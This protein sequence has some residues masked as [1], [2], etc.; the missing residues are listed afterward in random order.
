MLNSKLF[1]L[2]LISIISLRGFS[3]ENY[4]IEKSFYNDKRGNENFKK[5]KNK[6]FSRDNPSS[7]I[8][9]NWIKLKITNL[10]K[11][12]EYCISSKIPIQNL[13]FYSEGKKYNLGYGSP[14]NKRYFRIGL[15]VALLDIPFKKNIEYFV[16]L[17][18]E[19]SNIEFEIIEK[20]TL[21]NKNA[22]SDQ[23][24]VFFSGIF[25]VMFL[26]N[27]FLYFSIKEKSQLFYTISIFFSLLLWLNNASF[28]SRFVYPNYSVSLDFKIGLIISAIY[29]V[30]LILFTQSFLRLKFNYPNWNKYFNFLI[31]ILMLIPLIQFLFK[32]DPFLLNGP[33]FLS[34]L[35]LFLSILLLSFIILIRKQRE[36]LYFFIGNIVFF[37][38][39]I[40]FFLSVMELIPKIDFHIFSMETGT[41]FQMLF[42]SFAIADKINILKKDNEIANRKVIQQLQENNEIKSEINT[43]LEIE[44]KER[45]FEIE[46]QKNKLQEKN[47]EI[48]DSITY[49][50]RIQSAILPQPKLVKE[51][52]EDS[53]VLYKPKDIV[54]GDFY[55]LEVVGDTVLFA[56]ADCTGHGVPGAMVSV[57]CNNGLNRAVREHKLTEPNQIL[58]KTRELV[59]EEFEKSDEEVKDGMDI[60]LCA[61][62]T[63]TNTLKWAGAN[64]PLWILRKNEQGLV[65]VLETKPDKQPIGKHFD[66]KPF[67][68]TEFQ[69]EKDDIIYIFTDGY[70]DQFGGPKEKKYRVAQMRELFL[71][72]TSKTMEEQRKIINESFENWKGVLEQV[73]DVCIIGVR[74]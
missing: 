1:V 18:S 53:F 30:F 24:Q 65:E 10:S 27:L 46:A 69:L 12:T 23:V 33:S 29:G 45:T 31:F 71:S 52:L 13:Y 35:I 8:G 59:V 48:T 60:S 7:T 55:W 11:K 41:V 14:I 42:F 72:L 19:I 68:L 58:N 70:Q 15:N 28:F 2:I 21:I 20:Q 74:I 43:R 6:I 22:S 47:K 51:F 62:N 61:L 4:I 50:K 57:V 37:L 40:Y 66:A 54:A 56:A 5:I 39:A 63:K 67:S 36:I 38:F 17:P 9:K 34:G 3:A 25:L 73:D 26:Y 49:A 16:E 32:I 44:V 64:N